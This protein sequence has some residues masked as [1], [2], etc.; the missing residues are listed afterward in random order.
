MILFTL[1]VFIYL[2]NF[3]AASKN[4]DTSDDVDRCLNHKCILKCCPEGEYVKKKKICA[5]F[6]KDFD[7]SKLKV[8][9]EDSIQYIGRSV[10]ETFLYKPGKFVED[11]D[12]RAEAMPWTNLGYTAYILQVRF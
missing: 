3:G 9:N 2:I 10:Q 4:N 5:P 11:P 8:Y 1:S 7:M 12:F 6:N